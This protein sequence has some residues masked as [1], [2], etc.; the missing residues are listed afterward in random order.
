VGETF[1]RWPS[2]V[3]TVTVPVIAGQH[4]DDT[5]ISLWLKRDTI[6]YLELKHLSVRPHLTQEPKPRNNPVVQVGQFRFGQ[7][8][9]V[10]LHAH[11]Q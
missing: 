2:S 1:Q 8:I 11:S 4:A 10:D 3:M 5:A 6:A 7:L 9:D